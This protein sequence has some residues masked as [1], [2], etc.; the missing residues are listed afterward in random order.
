MGTLGRAT[1]T[2]RRILLTEDP[3]PGVIQALFV[4]LY[5]LDLVLRAVGG[6]GAPFGPGPLVGLALVGIVG[7]VAAVAPWATLPRWAVVTVPLLDMAALGLSRMD[8]AG[9]GAGLLAVLP[10]LWLGRKFGMR[11]VQVAVAGAAFL[12]VIPDLV[13]LGA[14]GVNLSRSVLILCT[15]AW[16]SLAISSALERSEANRETAERGRGEL[17]AALAVIEEQRA[18]SEAILDTVD[19]GLVLLDPDGTYRSMN[20]RH[21][22][23]M[24]IGY[25]DGHN[26]RAGQV[27][28]IYAADGVTPLGP[29]EMPTY[30]ASQGEEFDDCRLWIGADPLTRRAIS[31]SARSVRDQGDFAGAALAYKDVTEFMRA[32]KVKDEFV[33]SVSHELRTPLTSIV[34]YVDILQDRPDLPGDVLAQLDVVARNTDRLNRLVADLLHTAQADDGPMHV[35]RSETDLGVI[36]RDSVQAAT[37]AAERAG[38][39]IEVD[40]PL[41]LMVMADPQRMAQVVDNLVSNAIKYTAAGGRVRVRVAVDGAKVELSVA[42]TGIGIG[43]SDRDRLF[44]RFFRSRQAEERSIQGVGLGLSIT[45]AIVESHGGRIEVES[46]LGQGSEF[47]VRLPIGT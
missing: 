7:V 31:V 3:H 17:A 34:G 4:A 2:A 8:A 37:P 19:V 1:G 40:A 25:P 33:A 12:I 11:G 27:G 10:A 46:E 6:G 42:D 35:V 14:S 23:F 29:H 15:V 32:L 45:K 22:A 47:R 26:G 24:R 20:K 43:A 41:S 21:E 30:R 39:G 44:T 18:F 13:H 16:A 38:V 28:Q 36:V 5:V 9:A